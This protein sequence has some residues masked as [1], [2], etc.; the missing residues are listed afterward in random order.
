[1]RLK[2]EEGMKRFPLISP[3]VIARIECWEAEKPHENTLDSLGKVLGGA[4]KMIES[5]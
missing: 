3:N 1:M 4:P 2:G 5:Y